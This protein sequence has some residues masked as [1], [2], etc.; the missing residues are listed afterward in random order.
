MK[1]RVV[2]TGIG[3][4][5]PVAIGTEETWS[6]ICR[7]QS[8]IAPITLFDAKEYASRIAG[9]V[10][11]FDPTQ[12][13]DKKDL[14][15]TA[16]FIHFGVAAA[17]MALKQSGLEVTPENAERVGVFVGSGIGGFEVLE[18]EHRHYLERGPRHIS[19]FFFPAILVNIAAGRISMRT[20]A[21]GPNSATATAC[22]TGAHSIGEGF[23]IVQRGEADVMIS[24]GSEA[25]VT[26]L[27]VGGFVAMRALSGRNDDPTR[28]SRPWDRDRDGFVVGEGA[29]VLVLEE[30]EFALARGA[31]I[32]GEIVGYG[33]NSDAHHISAPPENGDGVYRVMTRAMNDAGIEPGQVDYL[34]AHA[35][36][37]PQGDLA[38]ATAIQRRFAGSTGKLSVS[39]SKSMTGH[40]L[41][42]A[43]AL[44]AGITVLALRDQIAPPTINLDNIA[45]GIDLDLVPNTAKPKAME[46]AVS[47][48][49]GFGGT[50]AC[51]VFRKAD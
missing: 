1:R 29:G 41:G 45:E 37:T 39:S 38:E 44:E 15:K 21:K 25:T 36:S 20:G 10:K 30:R 34:N 22:S 8:G 24:G 19:P 17:E 40:L 13:F 49:F 3:L 2:V 23:R 48:S 33:L 47:N 12:W 32:I 4:V 16:R 50:N 11:N 6:G 14:K 9:E 46:Y 35:T 28:A 43:G 7:G 5:S 18:R 31:R 51:L 27:A 26:P 42:G